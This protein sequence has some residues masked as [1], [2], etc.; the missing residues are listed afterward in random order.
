MLTHK[1]PSHFGVT[2]ALSKLTDEGFLRLVSGDN[3]VLL[4]GSGCCGLLEARLLFIKHTDI[5]NY[6]TSS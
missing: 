4:D 1:F 6:E 5:C 3:K 2:G